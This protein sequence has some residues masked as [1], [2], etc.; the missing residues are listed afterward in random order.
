MNYPETTHNTQPDIRQTK[1]IQKIS[2]NSSGANWQA[3]PH[4]ILIA[5]RRRIRLINSPILGTDNYASEY[6]QIPFE[7]HINTC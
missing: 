6:R 3:N 7:F 2:S 5:K 1:P 4:R